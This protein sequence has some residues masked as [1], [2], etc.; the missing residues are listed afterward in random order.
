MKTLAILTL[1]LASPA[2]AACPQS[3]WK[4]ARPGLEAA[5]SAEFPEAEHWRLRCLDQS[6][7][8]LFLVRIAATPGIEPTHVLASLSPR[9]PQTVVTFLRRESG[10]R[11]VV[12]AGCGGAG[13]GTHKREGS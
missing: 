4:A 6:L 1:L 8:G 13:D 3:T 9:G 11:W 2:Y 12:V 7:R 10:A 5:L